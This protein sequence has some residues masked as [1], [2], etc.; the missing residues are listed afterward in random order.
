M[1]TRTCRN[2]FT[3]PDADGFGTVNLDVIEYLRCSTRVSTTA[4]LEAKRTC[5][6]VMHRSLPAD[7]VDPGRS[8]SVKILASVA[9]NA[10]A[11][12]EVAADT[13]FQPRS[14]SC[15]FGHCPMCANARPDT[16][17][18]RRDEKLIRSTRL[19]SCHQLFLQLGPAVFAIA[20]N[21]NIRQRRSMKP[22]S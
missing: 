20:I 16:P 12:S 6:Q 9:F 13:A 18:T 21:R 22:S 4:I 3:L 8:G 7:N 17:N 2:V 10:C 1:G 19:S 5:H 11:A 14:G 15:A